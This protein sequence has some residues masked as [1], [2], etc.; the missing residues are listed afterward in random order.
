M[1]DYLSKM[2]GIRRK[3]TNKWCINAHAME[4]MKVYGC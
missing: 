2:V 1:N 4:I 3:K